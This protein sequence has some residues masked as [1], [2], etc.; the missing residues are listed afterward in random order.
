MW[1]Q[2]IVALLAVISD[3]YLNVSVERWRV[4][5]KELRILSILT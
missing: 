5:P 2:Y 4:I 1:E 3:T